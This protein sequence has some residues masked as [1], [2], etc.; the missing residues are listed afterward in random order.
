MFNSFF[1][2]GLQLSCGGGMN[3]NRDVIMSPPSPVSRCQMCNGH[4]FLVGGNSAG[5]PLVVT[6]SQSSG[7]FSNIVGSSSSPPIRHCSRERFA[8][9]A[10][11]SSK[12]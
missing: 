3:S 7:P 5:G 10:P 11:P 12:C 1:F 2:V 6:T 9:P 8:R 4:G